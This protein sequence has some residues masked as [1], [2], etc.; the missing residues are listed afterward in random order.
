MVTSCTNENYRYYRRKQARLRTYFG[1]IKPRKGHLSVK[2]YRMK[3]AYIF[4]GYANLNAITHKTLSYSLSRWHFTTGKWK[5]RIWVNMSFN[6]SGYYW[7]YLKF[8]AISFKPFNIAPYPR[9]KP[10]WRIFLTQASTSADWNASLIADNCDHF[11]SFI[12]REDCRYLRTIRGHT[13]KQI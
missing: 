4:S 9:L 2:L 3:A 7:L 6:W 12:R 11:K 13:E 1:L 10:F 8:Q 5:N